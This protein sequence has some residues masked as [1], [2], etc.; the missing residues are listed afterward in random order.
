MLQSM[1]ENLRGWVAYLLVGL[2]IVVFGLFGAEALF[3]GGLTQDTVA[4]VNGRKV[5][6]LDVR[7]A[8]EMRKQQLREMLGENADPRFFSDEFLLPSVR[9]GVIQQA[10]LATAVEKS[11]LRISNKTLDKRIVDDT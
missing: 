4:E 6:E 8:V 7:R 1:R 2:I 11:G 10:V 5:T 3:M 9:E